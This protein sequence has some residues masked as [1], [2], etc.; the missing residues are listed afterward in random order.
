[1]KIHL[2]YFASLREQLGSA[3]TVELPD[4]LTVGQLRDQLLARS[5]AYAQAPANIGLLLEACWP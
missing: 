2:R 3:E 1:M 4:G 5:A